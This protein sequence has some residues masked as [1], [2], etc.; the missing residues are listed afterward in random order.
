MKTS[1]T[2]RRRNGFVLL[3]VLIHFSVFGFSSNIDVSYR[4]RGI[5]INGDQKRVLSNSNHP[6]SDFRKSLQHGKE[7]S[8]CTN[9]KSVRGPIT[10][11]FCQDGYVITNVNFA[12]YGNPTGTCEHFRHGNCGAPATLRLVKKNCLG[13]PKC[14]FLV[15]DEMFG[16]SHCKGPPTLAVDATCTKT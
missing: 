2:F 15:T 1:H 5:K 10:R 14:V 3:L 6:R 13:K 9:H 12:D 11:I 4:A 16:P 7:H 8:A